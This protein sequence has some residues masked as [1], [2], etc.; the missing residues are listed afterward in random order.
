[1]FLK[2]AILFFLV[3]GLSISA[4][5]TISNLQK[6]CLDQP[7]ENLPK[8]TYARYVRQLQFEKAKEY[9]DSLPTDTKNCKASSRFWLGT[10]EFAKGNLE[11]AEKF[12][13]EGIELM[14]PSR[15]VADWIRDKPKQTGWGR[16]EDF[17]KY[18]QNSKKLNP[19]R[20]KYTQVVTYF[21]IDQT[22]TKSDP[23]ANKK[24]ERHMDVCLAVHGNLSL[25]ILKKYVELFSQGHLSLDI[26]SL[27]VPKTITKIYKNDFPALGSLSQW[28]E[29]FSL[30]MKQVT[31]ES[32]L[33][34]FAYPRW[35]GSAL[36][37]FSKIPIVPK[38]LNSPL[39][40][41]IKIASEDLSIINYP[42]LFHEYL[43]TVEYNMRRNGD[44]L[45]HATSHGSDGKKVEAI[46]GLK[47]EE[48]GETDWAEHHF[49]NRIPDLVKKLEF[50][51]SMNGWQDIFGVRIKFK[52]TF[53][54]ERI[55]SDY[56][57]YLDILNSSKNIKTIEE[58]EEESESSE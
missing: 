58:M 30:F 39:R 42:R 11:N 31:Q 10:S 13:Q 48:T 38:V 26:R 5:S 44:K 29:N 2:I 6:K 22:N 55:R 27:F 28:D 12:F 3:S 34:V 40:T 57:K 25:S 51:N 41:H 8:D 7:N 56:V 23:N 1:M 9:C 20:P 53:T 36:A 54:E 37:S 32:D 43:H 24:V 45:F 17:L 50:K 16:P 47:T 18:I 52:D 21:I 14:G 49:A 33:I 15:R 46:T 19:S 4:D 35:S